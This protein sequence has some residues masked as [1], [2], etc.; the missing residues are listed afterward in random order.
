[1]LL[2]KI[3][4]VNLLLISIFTMTNAQK[5]FNYTN[6]WKKVDELVSKKG[7]TESALKEVQTI[8]NAAKTE[9]NNAQLIKALVFRIGLQ[10]QKEEDAD[11]KAIFQLEKEAAT[12]TEPA[13]SILLNLTAEAYWQ[14]FQNNRWKFYDR[15]NTQSFNKEDIATWTTDDLHKKISAL[16]L[17]SLQQ[18]KLLQQT[19]LDEFDPIITKGNMRQLRPTL[20]DLLAFRAVSYFENDERSI[21]K[22]TD[23][24]EMNSAAAFSPAATFIQQKFTTT[25]SSSLQNKA[26]L[27][28]QEIIAFH[29]N[30]AKPDALIDA[31]IHRISFVNRTS[32]LENKTELYRSAL[33]HLIKQYKDVPAAAQASFLLAQDYATFAA[34]YDFKKHKSN[35]E[36]NPRYYYQKAMAICREVMAQKEN[37][38]G[39]VNCSNLVN[40]IGQ[41]DISITSEKVNIPG[42]PFRSLLN[43]RNTTKAFFRIV[44]MDKKAFDDMQNIRWQDE[45][46]KKILA[47]PALKNFSYNLAASEDYQ[48]HSAEIK[49]DALPEGTYLLVA[50]TDAGFEL[51]KNTLAVQFLYVSNIAWM[52]HNNEFFIV[53]RESGQPLKNASVILWEQAY[54]SKQ[55]KY[56]QVKAGTYTS[57]ANGN[58]SINKAPGNNAYTRT[59]EITYQN[60]HLH[61][62][63][64]AYVYVYKDEEE[65]VNEKEA[66]RVFFF[67]DRSI[68]RPG[69]TV[70]FKGI[71]TTTDA[72]T[73]KPKIVSGLKTTVILYDAN[74]EELDSLIVTS[75]EFGSVSG[76]FVIPTGRMTGSYSIQESSTENATEFSVEEYKRPKFFVEYQPVKQSFRVDDEIKVTG[77]AKAYAGNN[78]DGALVK[79]RVVREPRLL[80]PWLCW[81]WG[82]PQMDEQEIAH[83]ETKTNADG[84]F[85]IS[86]TA[87]ADKKVRKELSPVFDYRIITDVTDINGETRSAET[88]ISA[89]YQSLQLSVSLPQGEMMVVDSLKQ[90]NIST[91]NMMGEFVKSNVT[92]AVYKLN[93]PARLIRERYWDQPDQFLLNEKDYIAAFPNDE[94]NNETEKESWEKSDKIGVITDTSSSNSKFQI[95][96]LK[97]SPGWYIIEAATTDKDGNEVKNQAFVQLVDG[98]TKNPVSPAYVWNLPAIKTA[99]PGTTATLSFGTS[100]NEVYVVEINPKEYTSNLRYYQLNNEQKQINAAVT[101]KERGGFGFS[102][103]FVKNNRFFSFTRYINVPWTN[104]ELTISYETFRDKTLP[105]SE[106][107]WKVKIS[108]YKADKVAAELLTSMYDASLDQF[109]QHQWMNPGLFSSNYFN[110]NWSSGGFAVTNSVNR[111]WN[112]YEWKNFDK[113]YDEMIGM[114]DDRPV[115]MKMPKPVFSPQALEMKQEERSDNGNAVTAA[116]ADT[117][118]FNF[119][120]P[121]III[122]QTPSVKVGDQQQNQNNDAVKIRKNFNETAFFFPDLKTDS[123]GNISFSFTMP[124]ALTQWKWQL[125]SHTKDLS[126]GV[127][128]KSI[129]TQKDLMVQPFAPRFLREGDR[130]EF[131]AKI[132]NL[133]D[134]ELSGESNLQ[135]FNTTT[136][137]PVD[138]WFQN[139]FPVQHFTIA[140]GQSTVVKFRTE[141]PY[142]FNEALTYRIIAKA[143]DKSDGEE[144]TLPV[145][146]NRMLVTETLPLPMRGDGTKNFSFTKL[147]QSDR[148]ETLTQ[149]KFTIEYTSNP[150]WYAVQALP[151]LMEY[152]YEC[153][154]QTWNR[155]YANALAS[156][157]TAKLPRIKEVM[158]KWKINNSSELQSKLQTNE[159]L[160]SVLLVETPWILDAKNEEQQKK[161]ISLLFD[162]IRMSNELSKNIAKLQEMQLEN[163]G[164][165]WFKGG[166][167]DRYITQYIVTGIGHLK[168]LNALPQAQEKTINEILA[169]AIPYLDKK[170]KEDYDNLI[171]YKANLKN[172]NLSYTAIQYLYMRSFFKNIP[173]TAASQKAYNYYFKQS[174]QYWLQQS[175]YMQGMI[176]LALHRSND[177]KTSTAIVKS[178]KENALVNEEMGM[179]WKEFNAGYYWYQAP[180]EAQALMIEVFNDVTNDQQ[181]VADL[182]TWLL[183]QKQTQNWKTTIATA[184][185]CYALLLQGGKWIATEPVV[186]I[187]AGDQVFS[188]STEKT[189]AGTGYFKR[190]LQ[191]DFIKPSM[192]NIKVTVSNSNNQPSW[193]AAYWQYFENLDKITS[194]ETPLKLQ[195]KYFVERNTNNGPVL[196]PVNEG[197]EL[198]VGDKIKVR[199]E[200][201]VD[202]NMEYVHMKDMRPSCM[203]PVNV[204]SEYKWQGGLGYYESTKDASTSFFFN[205]LSKGT[206]VFEYPMFI[207]HAGN[208]SSGITTIQCMYAP[209]FSSHS[210]GVRV[211]VGE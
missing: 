140:A 194:A 114:V 22:P 132:T 28:L 135:L 119:K 79:Y 66:R 118:S 163:G 31:D 89:G 103:S 81:R 56:V 174:Q 63:D 111:N 173:V 96:N 14:Y 169:T 91:Q 92:V 42:K 188:T 150:A 131:T 197:D 74:N 209:E 43:Y 5:K 85:N 9:K 167:D 84:T 80:Y 123:A 106:E 126:M 151:Y 95:S 48:K 184:E 196:T 64:R 104:K 86:F 117:A 186:E 112:D 52:H 189:E 139:T 181:S 208:Y 72:E 24:F 99:E 88:T 177:S 50:S 204:L 13:K 195:K 57:N 33:A 8:Y 54:D 32:T 93:A 58:F 170:I 137:Q 15:T 83:G 77:N 25:D 44:K 55:S 146:T 20:F 62:D 51:K 116:A 98:K 125:L 37:S 113:R 157:I 122:K 7:L 200:L 190:S 202:R 90:I 76:K 26:L 172:N 49:V 102:Y 149:H 141:V 128:E 115:H 67:T 69:Q 158:A 129:I 144:A 100:A 127:S 73:K 18:K 199:I 210:E 75:N 61:L 35:D 16:Y 101:E 105:G 1:M 162:A 180:V 175:R 120:I 192:G 205:W 36:Q 21:T 206:Y 38:E 187:K 19:K 160:K 97:F 176:A 46:W 207:T 82:W 124:E 94:Y 138:G 41:T 4:L 17:A 10:Q 3:L 155:F 59:L 30:D 133:T 161:N 130:F 156:H 27:L 136:M 12:A 29:I 23:A 183:K 2:K 53:N 148:S 164:F 198:K 165:V 45:F 87:I 34:T 60:D 11:V 68:Y 166:P 39:K 70:Y 65:K 6:A 159:E 110:N 71:I 121:A 191:N 107:Q 145:L 134:K 154:E 153:A 185:A 152:P 47:A 108:G 109:K 193:G 203:E 211:K 40:N 168:K 182:K 142:N 147:L 78:I 179:Y 201:R 143:A 171:R 178:L